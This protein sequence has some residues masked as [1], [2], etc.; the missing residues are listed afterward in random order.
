MFFIIN[1]FKQKFLINYIKV[2]ELSKKNSEITKGYNLINKIEKTN[3]LDCSEGR[4]YYES[5]K[6]I[7]FE[8][9]I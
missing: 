1:S 4:N 6:P 2:K 9:Y 3:L 7:L 5:I 8:N